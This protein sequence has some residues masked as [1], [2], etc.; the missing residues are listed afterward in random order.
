MSNNQRS[1]LPRQANGE[2]VIVDKE[3]PTAQAVTEY[4]WISSDHFEGDEELA[5]LPANCSVSIGDPRVLGKGSEAQ[6]TEIREVQLSFPGGD[7]SNFFPL[8]EVIIEYRDNIG[9]MVK[10]VGTGGAEFDSGYGITYVSFGIPI[11]VAE[12]IR[13]MVKKELRGASIVFEDIG[14]YHDHLWIYAKLPNDRRNALLPTYMRDG[15]G[16]TTKIDMVRALRAIHGNIS[17]D[18]GVGVRVTKVKDDAFTR[19]TNYKLSL[20]LGSVM[21]G[22]R[23]KITS[24]PL[25]STFSSDFS[26]QT[27]DGLLNLLSNLTVDDPG[28]KGDNKKHEA[29]TIQD[30]SK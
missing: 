1:P 6:K 29:R 13:E 22:S 14:Q 19:K 12:W 18:V 7:V 16:K 3:D 10:K 11:S 27:S 8:S 28:E 5:R 23:T 15:K 21:I 2:Y 25:G 26:G 24:P 9:L 20:T 30:V 17:C 4:A